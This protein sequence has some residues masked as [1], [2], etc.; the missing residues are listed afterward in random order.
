MSLLYCTLT[1]VDN[2]TP[3][4]DILDISKEYPFVE[5]G[6]LVSED[7]EGSSR[8]PTLPMVE[9][10]LE[11]DINIAIHLCGSFNT[12][13]LE[14]NFY[15]LEKLDE[16]LKNL[17][18]SKGS[19]RLQLNISNYYNKFRLSD[20]LLLLENLRYLNIITSDNPGNSGMLTDLY[21]LFKPTFHQVLFDTSGGR[22]KLPES[23]PKPNLPTVY[24]YAGG[25]SLDNIEQEFIKIKSVVP[26]GR[27]FWIDM[28]S[29]LRSSEDT[30]D[31][32]KCRQILEIINRL[33]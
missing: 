28:E 23:W 31:L 7:R 12:Y 10:L 22:G 16:V 33:K 17:K 25:L 14:E 15:K 2:T 27:P 30:F 18:E 3:I 8:Y 5:W 1:G 29:S 9:D 20:L 21:S 19:R 24:G 32:S 11:E 4:K 6:V 13:L 26:E